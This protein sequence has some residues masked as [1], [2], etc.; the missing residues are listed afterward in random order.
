MARAVAD[1]EQQRLI[2][3][4]R[5]MGAKVNENAIREQR[6]KE[7]ATKKDIES[8]DIKADHVAHS[9]TLAKLRNLKKCQTP[10]K[11]PSAQM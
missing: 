5:I 2:A 7:R 3:H 11:S 10:Q 8:V 1:A 9:E 4:A 6:E